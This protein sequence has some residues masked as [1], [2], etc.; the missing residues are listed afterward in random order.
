MTQKE[1][2]AKLHKFMRVACGD[3]PEPEDDRVEDFHPKRDERGRFMKKPPQL[4]IEP[5]E[6]EFKRN[7]GVRRH[8]RNYWASICKDGHC[9]SSVYNIC[10][11]DMHGRNATQA[12]K[13]GEMAVIGLRIN[14]ENHLSLKGRWPDAVEISY[15]NYLANRSPYQD[16]FISKDGKKMWEDKYV[17][18]TPDIAGNMLVAAMCAV[19][20]IVEFPWIP[21]VWQEL[22]KNNVPDDIAYMHAY[23]ITASDEGKV[24]VSFTAGHSSWSGGTFDKKAALNFIRH[25]PILIGKETY[26]NHREYA[27]MN[28][29][30]GDNFREYVGYNGHSDS[31]LYDRLDDVKALASGKKPSKNPFQKA[32]ASVVE[33]PDFCKHWAPILNAEYIKALLEKE[34]A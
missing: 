32:E 17:F 5:I 10:F 24:T 21:V 13:L 18:F 25:N 26:N 31:F 11:A 6:R 30:F 22:V 19:R 7:D 9:W 20:M 4:K 2:I 8:S 14:T 29:L 16:A 27:G 3:D 34:D 12:G 23:Q 1:L 33:I 28:Y 15:L